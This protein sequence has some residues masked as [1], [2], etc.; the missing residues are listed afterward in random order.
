MLIIYLSQLVRMLLI[1][2]FNG[3]YSTYIR[4]AKSFKILSQVFLIFIARKSLKLSFTAEIV[5]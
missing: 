3:L 2:Q 4:P 5:H 1:G